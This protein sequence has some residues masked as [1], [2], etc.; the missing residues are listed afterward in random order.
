ME[1]LDLETVQHTLLVVAAVEQ[2]PP[3]Q[4]QTL[5]EGVLEETEPHHLYPV[6]Q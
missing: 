1:P 5:R 2:I 6:L 4:P 3:E